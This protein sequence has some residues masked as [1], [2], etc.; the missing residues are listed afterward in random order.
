MCH[1]RCYG[2]RSENKKKRIKMFVS[3]LHKQSD[4]VFHFCPFE[5]LMWQYKGCKSFKISFAIVR[6][7][8]NSITTLVKFECIPH[9]IFLIRTVNNRPFWSIINDPFQSL[10]IAYFS[11]SCSFITIDSFKNSF[12]QHTHNFKEPGIKF[13]SK[14]IHLI[15]SSAT[16]SSNI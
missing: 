8:A 10:I 4:D 6:R 7:Q 14:S 15:Y 3:D 13:W 11:Y 5:M 9:S 12:L 16:S 1:R 2:L